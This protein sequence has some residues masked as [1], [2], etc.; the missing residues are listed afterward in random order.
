MTVLYVIGVVSF[1]G[2]L[3]ISMNET[4]KSF[5]TTDK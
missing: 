5:S 2:A 1:V 4:I 3:L